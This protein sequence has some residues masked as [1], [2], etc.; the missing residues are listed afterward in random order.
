MI[1]ALFSIAVFLL[2]VV[3]SFAQ[4]PTLAENYFSKGDFEKAVVLYQDLLKGQPS[5]STYFQRLVDCYQQLEKFAESEKVIQTRLSQYKQAGLIVELGY[6]AQLKKD[7][8]EAKKRYAEAISKIEQNPAEVYGVAQAFERHSLSEYALQAYQLAKTKEPRL[9]FNYQMGMLYGQLGKTDEMI[10]MFLDEA[11]ANPQSSLVIQNRLSRFMSE[12]GAS[13]FPDALKKALLVRAQKNQDVFW[14]EYLSWFYVQQKEYGK[15]FVQEKAIYRRNPESLGN[16][17]NLAQLSVQEKDTESAMEIYGFVLENAQDLST[18]IDA[19]YNLMKIRINAA[20]EKDNAQIESDLTKLIQEF[21]NNPETVRLQLLQAHFATFNQNNPGKGREIIQKALE[22]NLN[23]YLKAELKMELA[24]IFLYEQKFNQALL[25]YSQIE[26]DLKNDAVGHQAS[27]MTAKT[28]YFKGD[29]EWAQTQFTT[30]KSANTQLIAN[31]ALEYF[32]L[33]SDNTVAD[34]TQTALKEFA[35]ADYL[36]Y[37][38]KPK[39][40]REKFLQVLSQFKGNEIEAVTELRIGRIDEK[41]GDFNAALDRYKN[42]IDNHADGI[43][44]DEAYYFSALI[45]A[46]KLSDPEKAKTLLE[47]VI[48]EHQDSIYFV[49]AR[50]KYRTLRGDST[51]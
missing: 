18:K 32:L 15:A 34:S 22:L 25:Y 48:F 41:L 4:N 33:I 40:A 44:V 30:L 45:Y 16:I 3:A 26:D 27:L 8:S 31:D 42:I 35:K 24:D 38:N 12:D 39:P 5:N 14:N 6:N 17:L 36:L 29:F 1:R 51:L 21:G 13:D 23:R 46:D 43:Y 28:S 49:E 7:E 47:K 10:N 9:N 19:N 2:S 37:Q 20:S 11:F 50:K